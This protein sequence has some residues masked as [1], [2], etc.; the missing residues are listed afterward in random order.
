MT[1]EPQ[2]SVAVISISDINTDSATVSWDQVENA[3]M[4]T[5]SIEG[6]GITEESH[7]PTNFDNAS[8][9]SSA[10]ISLQAG[11]DYTVRIV[12]RA[13]GYR[14]SES[15]ETFT[16]LQLQLPAVRISISD[17]N[18]DSATVSWVEVEN[19]TTYTVT[20][21][22]MNGIQVGEESVLNAASSSQM[23]T[24]LNV[25]TM[26]TVS[27]VTSAPGYRSNESIET[28]TTLQLQ[29][30]ATVI[31]ISDISTASAMVSWVDVENATTYTVNVT[32]VNGIQVGE[33]SVLDAASS[34]QMLTGLDASTTY[35]VSVVT[36]AP[37]YRSNESDGDIHNAT[38]TVASNS[39]KH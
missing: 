2:L 31:S 30:P 17:I 14:S 7:P 39:N 32:D 25:S 11:E 33:E 28:F 23:L 29:L 5:V 37:G 34:S 20:V 3:T 35:T 13:T 12:A 26:Y 16:T 21:T 19:A 4:Y 15:M 24:G 27:V 8:V 9:R 38:V 18:T 1:L 6:E 22:D 36:S 10:V